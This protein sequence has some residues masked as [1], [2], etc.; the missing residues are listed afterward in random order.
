MI[1]YILHVHVVQIS[2]CDQLW[3][4]PNSQ[5]HCV[6]YKRNKLLTCIFEGLQLILPVLQ[7]VCHPSPHEPVRVPKVA[8]DAMASQ[9]WMI[10][11]MSV[12]TLIIVLDLIGPKLPSLILHNVGCSLTSLY[13]MQTPMT[14]LLTNIF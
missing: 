9:P 12:V 2:S 8:V 5:F 10:V 4:S 13:S 6:A 7:T 1:G 3:R 11:R 14:L